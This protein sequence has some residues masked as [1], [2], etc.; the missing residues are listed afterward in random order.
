MK[1]EGFHAKPFG[2]GCGLW[3][4]VGI[5]LISPFSVDMTAFFRKTGRAV[6]SLCYNWPQIAFVACPILMRRDTKTLFVIF[7]FAPSWDNANEKQ[8]LLLLFSD[9]IWFTTRQLVYDGSYYTKEQRHGLCRNG[10]T[11]LKYPTIFT[12]FVPEVWRSRVEGI[13]V[14]WEVSKLVH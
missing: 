7:L 4:V 5:V 8:D 12:C 2:M 14:I 3:G 13:R 11:N 6:D 10:K 1:V 9:H